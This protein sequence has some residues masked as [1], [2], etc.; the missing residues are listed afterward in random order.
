[1][2]KM[3]RNNFEIILTLYIG[4]SYYPMVINNSWLSHIKTLTLLLLSGISKSL[5][6]AFLYR[7]I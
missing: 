6:P 7:I 4:M 1:M 2:S 3:V 5:L